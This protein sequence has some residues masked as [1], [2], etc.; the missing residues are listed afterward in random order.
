MNGEGR[1]DDTKQGHLQANAPVNCPRL[2]EEKA[3]AH[4]EM[5]DEGGE[6]QD[7]EVGCGGKGLRHRRAVL[8]IHV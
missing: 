3:R 5:D 1:R 6:E 2:K 8:W 7:A 4:F